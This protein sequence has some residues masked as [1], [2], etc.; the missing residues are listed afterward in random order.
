MAL[1]EAFN[2]Y[3]GLM[4]YSDQWNITLGKIK[5][6]SDRTNDLSN[7]LFRQ[8]GYSVEAWR[9]LRRGVL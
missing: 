5:A 2:E 6:L 4:P 9:K 3:D 1:V 8:C 7:K